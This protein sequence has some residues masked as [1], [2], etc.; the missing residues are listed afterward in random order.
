MTLL[1]DLKEVYSLLGSARQ[2]WTTFIA[3]F[4]SL[5]ATR[6]I[7]FLSLSTQRCKSRFGIVPTTIGKWTDTFIGRPPRLLLKDRTDLIHLTS[8]ND[9]ASFQAECI[10]ISIELNV[11]G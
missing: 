4:L 8:I 3:G 7:S 2:R 6:A 1:G 10:C 5:R 9:G 11:L